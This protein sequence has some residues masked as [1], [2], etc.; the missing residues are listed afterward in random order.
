MQDVTIAR[1]QSTRVYR[2]SLLPSL[3]NESLSLVCGQSKYSLRNTKDEGVV[4]VGNLCIS[5]GSTQM[6]LDPDLKHLIRYNYQMT[7]SMP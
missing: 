4:V 1:L 7:N 3:L 5:L 6:D 2:Y